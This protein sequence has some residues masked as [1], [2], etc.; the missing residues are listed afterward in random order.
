MQVN[1]QSSERQI[2]ASRRQPNGLFETRSQR[3]DQPLE[4]FQRSLKPNPATEASELAQYRDRIK[5]VASPEVSKESLAE[6]AATASKAMAYFETHFGQAP[7]TLHFEVGKASDTLR[8]GYNFVK[9]VVSLPHV[10]SV[11]NA[12]LNSQDII[13]HEIFHAL[14]LKAYPGLP[15]PD[16]TKNGEV[17][18]H[19]GLADLFAH[20]LGPDQAFGEN[21][22]ISEPHV[23]EY[24]NS[25]RVSLAAGS[26]AQGN[27]ITSLLLQHQ[28]E[29][30]QIRSFLEAGD[31]SLEALGKLA[32]SLGQSLA[33]DAQMAVE[34]NVGSYPHSAKGRYWLEKD[35]PL[36][37]AFQPNQTLQEAHSDFRVVW[38][39]KQG[40]PSKKYVFEQ[41]ETNKFLV[42]GAPDA[43]SEK[44]IARFYDGDRV[45]GFKPF[46]F[47]VRDNKAA[48]E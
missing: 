36:E 32:P 23:R 7:T 28:I 1:P 42:S 8:T 27:A 43:D 37:I 9:D 40:L 21:Y 45:I 12:G 25:L 11:I 10:D 18:L 24:R 22:Y 17:R 5:I 13:N 48:G 14:L 44:V 35:V 20:R 41:T 6:L 31:F 2:K 30:E 33:R 39:D 29:N 46:Y 3:D 15:S 4:T 19:E 47:G 26:H 38:T 16:D 34:E